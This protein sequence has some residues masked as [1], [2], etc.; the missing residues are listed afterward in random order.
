[1]RVGETVPYDLKS[2][3][4]AH[5]HVSY[6]QLGEDLIVGHYL[7]YRNGFYV[8]VG[9]HDPMTFSNTAAFFL[10]RNWSGINIDADP[11]A[12]AKFYVPGQTTLT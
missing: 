2:Q 5:A 1:M 7:R 12:I 10:H 8:D 3:S 9:C 6:S 11:S 4:F